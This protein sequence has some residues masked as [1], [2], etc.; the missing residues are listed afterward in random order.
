MPVVE[1]EVKCKRNRKM[2]ST[3][4]M[5]S[6]VYALKSNNN[7]VFTQINNFIKPISTDYIHPNTHS[8]N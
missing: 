4:F 6:F 3:I 5:Q 2:Y 8:H 1:L 7:S